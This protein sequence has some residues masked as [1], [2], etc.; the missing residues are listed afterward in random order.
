M[1]RN[2]E[3]VKVGVVALSAALGIGLVAALGAVI[4][5]FGLVGRCH[6]WG[7]RGDCGLWQQDQRSGR[8]RGHQF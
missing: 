8:P 4:G 7:S 5:P 6:R 2:I 3:A 1:I